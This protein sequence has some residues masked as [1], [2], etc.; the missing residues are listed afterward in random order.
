MSC[1]QG[2]SSVEYYIYLVRQK[3]RKTTNKKYYRNNNPAYININE[4]RIGSHKRLAN[5]VFVVW[6][7]KDMIANNLDV[8]CYS[9]Y[10]LNAA[11]IKAYGT[12][13][14]KK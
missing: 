4:N 3:D 8:F 10:G 1:K 12:D 14:N 13:Y 2:I 9:K 5:A 11:L 7:V 6:R